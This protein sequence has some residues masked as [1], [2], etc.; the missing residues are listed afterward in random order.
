[1]KKLIW[2][3]I[4]AALAI[5]ISN[6]ENWAERKA[7]FYSANHITTSATTSVTS[8]TA[9]VSSIVIT[10]T[11]PGTTW[12]VQIANKE[13]TPKVLYASTGTAVTQGT[14]TIGFDVPVLM[15]SGIAITTAG[16]AG[17]MDVFITYWQL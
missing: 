6:A 10:V 12:T 11:N 4:A 14:F 5:P 16:T 7:P 13:T 1:M 3:L 9:Y 8:T 17:V 2:I 15:T